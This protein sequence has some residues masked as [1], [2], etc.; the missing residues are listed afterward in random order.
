M[1]LEGADRDDEPRVAGKVRSD[2]DPAHF[3]EHGHVLRF[4]GHG[5]A[6]RVNR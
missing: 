6:I 3:I 5:T 2:V 4:V 1:L